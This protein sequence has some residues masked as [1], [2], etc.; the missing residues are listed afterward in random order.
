MEDLEK[1]YFTIISSV[2]T[3]RSNY[4]EAI[5]KA[6]E[7]NFEEAEKLMK[8]GRDYF[9][10]GHKAHGELITK[11]ANGEGAPVSLLM[12]HAEDQLMSAEAFGILAEEFVSLYRQLK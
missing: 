5:H 1:V 12:I 9:V 3:A 2:G 10:E 4:I 7:G 6:K 11:E 8:E